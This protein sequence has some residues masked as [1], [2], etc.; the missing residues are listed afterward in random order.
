MLREHQIGMWLLL[1]HKRRE[2]WCM[3]KVYMMLWLVVHGKWKCVMGVCHCDNDA[4][5]AQY[6]LYRF[7]LLSNHEVG[8]QTNILNPMN[9]LSGKLEAGGY[10]A[11]VY[12]CV[13]GENKPGEH[14]APLK[15]RR[16][17]RQEP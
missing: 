8:L 17:H 4:A 6:M 15:N 3:V 10:G 1:L 7:L 11:G 12:T 5:L 2:L 9:R 14:A 16:C 13:F